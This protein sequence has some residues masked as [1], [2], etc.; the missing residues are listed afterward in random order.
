MRDV[1]ALWTNYCTKCQHIARCAIINCMNIWYDKSD[2]LLRIKCTFSLKA[3]NLIAR[4]FECFHTIQHYKSVSGSKV[5]ASCQ[6]FSLVLQ[7]KFENEIWINCLVSSVRYSILRVRPTAFNSP[8]NTTYL[9]RWLGWE[10]IQ[11]MACR[12]FVTKP[13][14][15]P[16]L[17]YCQFVY[18]EQTLVKF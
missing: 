14:L 17:T 7:S 3:N 8:P 2:F 15:E 11:V 4:L 13:L 6:M 18:K 9:R 5:V 10:W 1:P 16:T 12:L